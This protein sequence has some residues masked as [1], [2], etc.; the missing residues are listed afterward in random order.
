M[1][2]INF[3]M[4]YFSIAEFAEFVGITP[5]SL[6]NY[7]KMGIFAPAKYGGEGE[8]NK[9]RYYS[10]LQ[11]TTIK[12]IRVLTEIGVPLNTIKELAQNRTPE[13]LLRLLRKHK[14]MIA[15][16]VNFLQEV[17]SIIN[18][19]TELLYD[20]ISVTETEL[21]VC[22][23]PEK[24]IILGDIN[25]FSDA[26]GFQREFIRF[27]RY[28]HEPKL[29]MSYPVGG[30]W[31]SMNTFLDEPSKPVRFFSLD[32]KGHERK[33]SGL[34]LIGYTRG[35]YGQINDLP[36]QMTAYAKKHGLLFNGAVYNIYL[37]DE[38]SVI[39]PTQ[40][41]LQISASVKETHRVSSHRMQYR[42]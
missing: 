30:Y 8:R 26:S 22:E 24:K 33:Q 6:R 28:P 34:Y 21:S 14:E 39:D 29:N 17:Y 10:P 5:E 16:K 11:I 1:N 36:K 19:F 37:T 9:Y 4:N 13:K 3:D 38:L 12:M 31:E 20:A 27:C 35:Y 15:G 23:M 25:D 18:T 2:D 40:Y 7:D 32:P 42:F 41:L